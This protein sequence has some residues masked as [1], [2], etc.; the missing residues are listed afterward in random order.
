MA[1]CADFADFLT[2]DMCSSS[3]LYL[4]QRLLCNE[5]SALQISCPAADAV[6]SLFN[7]LLFKCQLPDQA[8]FNFCWSLQATP[9]VEFSDDEAAKMT[10]KIQNAGTEVVE[11]KAGKGSATLSMVSITLTE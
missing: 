11:A 7:C 9:K 1:L 8:V 5:G 6:V 2:V 10:D 4:W 3:I